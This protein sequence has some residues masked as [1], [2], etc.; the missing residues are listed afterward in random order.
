MYH[1]YAWAAGTQ[2]GRKK[3]DRGAV[4]R[5][6]RA[7]GTGKRLARLRDE[8]AFFAWCVHIKTLCCYFPWGGGRGRGGE[9][10]QLIQRLRTCYASELRVGVS[11]A[12]REPRLGRGERADRL[13][14]A[15]K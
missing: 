2:H 7:S 10:L 3:G 13:M 5:F 12:C 8:V 1:A 15:C 11:F 14:F 4:S 9:V 6:F